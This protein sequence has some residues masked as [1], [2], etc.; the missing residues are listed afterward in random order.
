MAEK[1]GICKV[2]GECGEGAGID[3]V[4]IEVAQL[5]SQ[6]LQAVEEISDRNG[7]AGAPCQRVMILE[8][9]DVV[10]RFRLRRVC[11]W[12]GIS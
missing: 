3:L 9:G 11:A 2:M 4:G 5:G 8:A 12:A 6:F 1:I 10:A 7:L